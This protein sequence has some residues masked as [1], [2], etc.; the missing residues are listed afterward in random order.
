MR[1]TFF[2]ILLLLLAAVCAG[3]QVQ[4]QP[5]DFVIQNFHFKSGE[6][7]PELRIHYYTLGTPQKD[8]KGNVTNAVLLLHGT[9]GSGRNYLGEVFTTIFAPGGP[10]D[11]AKFY[12][13]LPD[14]I[15]HGNSSKPSDGLHMRFPHYDYDDMVEAQYRLVTEGL[16][17][18]HLRLVGGISMGGMHTWLW[19]EQHPDFMDALF[20]LVSQPIEIAGRN[21][22][23]RQF[24][25][26]LIRKDPAWQEGEYKQQPPNLALV[27]EMFAIAVAGP[28]DAQKRASTRDAANHML[29]EVGSRYAGTMD[30]NDILYALEASRNYNPWPKLEAIRAPLVAVNAEDDFI[31]PPEL[32][33]M[34]EAMKRLKRGKYVLLKVADGAHGHGTSGATKMWAPVLKEFIGER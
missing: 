7:L 19:G 6:S 14:G 33:V 21:R 4:P 23:W 24:C 2:P 28:A 27:G 11:A 30:A 16:G 34:P 17:I 29:Q 25:E 12:I 5:G 13:I 26:D 3:A 31:N 20:P 18:H 9:S 32:G 10:L 8:A 22:M 15:G 1:K